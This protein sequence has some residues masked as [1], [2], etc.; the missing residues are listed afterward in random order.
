M[1][2]ERKLRKP[3]SSDTSQLATVGQEKIQDAMRP[4]V[5]SDPQEVSRGQREEDL[6][7][8]EFGSGWE[9]VERNEARV[10]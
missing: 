9:K 8:V 2:L 7:A 6:I 4:G 10:E 1:R 3:Q 5:T